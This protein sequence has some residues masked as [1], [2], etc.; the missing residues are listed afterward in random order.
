MRA[1]VN[2][3]VLGNVAENPIDEI[4]YERIGRSRTV[5]TDGVKNTTDLNRV[6]VY[7]AHEWNAKDFDLRGFIVKDIIIGR[8]R[9]FFGLYPEANYGPT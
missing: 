9:D 2:F 5:N 4:F 7:N 6:Q 3:N 8:M 1:N